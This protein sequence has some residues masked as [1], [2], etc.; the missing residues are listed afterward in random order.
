M[1][2][3]MAFDPAS[4]AKL[5]RMLHV[6]FGIVYYGAMSESVQ[7]L[8]N[9]AV[10][11]MF[12]TFKNP[13]GELEG[14]FIQTITPGLD[15]IEGKLENPSSHAWRRQAG[16]SGM[17]DSLGRFF[18]N[19]PGIDYMGYALTTDTSAVFD[20]FVLATQL[21]LIALGGI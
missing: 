19:D 3:S 11:Y 15:S 14:A 20:K 12:S 1:N 13:T 10:D 21:E 5:E 9:T 7:L 17:T 6:N 2:I 16:F 4:M 8:E 18:P